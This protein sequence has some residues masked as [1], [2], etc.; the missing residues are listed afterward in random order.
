MSDPLEAIATKGPLPGPDG[1]ESAALEAE[2]PPAPD[3]VEEAA[4][5]EEES[6]GEEDSRQAVAEGTPEKAG[7]E[8]EKTGVE[9]EGGGRQAVKAVAEGKVG[10]DGLDAESRKVWMKAAI[11]IAGIAEKHWEFLQAWDADVRSFRAFLRQHRWMAALA[12]AAPALAVCVLVLWLLMVEDARVR[13][14]FW[15]LEGTWVMEQAEAGLSGLE[16][17]P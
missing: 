12:Y 7:G 10:A 5:P 14:A 9:E 8:E 6:S 17:Q 13:V 3:A 1:S 11:A 16:A 4:V 15:L 2:A